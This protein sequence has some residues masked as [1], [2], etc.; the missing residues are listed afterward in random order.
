MALSQTRTREMYS[1][2]ILQFCGILRTFLGYPSLLARHYDRGERDIRSLTSPLFLSFIMAIK[3]LI[4]LV[5]DAAFWVQERQCLKQS[6]EA[7]SRSNARVSFHLCPPFHSLEHAAR[8][9][10]FPFRNLLYRDELRL[11]NRVG[12]GNIHVHKATQIPTRVG[13]RVFELQ[14]ISSETCQLAKREVRFFK[15]G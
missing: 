2:K 14:Q 12:F 6:L 11:R 13:F 7:A 8:I 10:L 5:T 1:L 3:G 15:E 4:E 9:E